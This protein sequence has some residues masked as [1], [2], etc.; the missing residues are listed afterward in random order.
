MAKAASTSPATA[1]RLFPC[2]RK[3]SRT[4]SNTLAKGISVGSWKTK[5]I[6]PS[7]S[8]CGHSIRPRLALVR[9]AISRRGGALAATRR[10]QEAH[11]L[12]P[13]DGEVEV[14]QRLRP[15]GEQLGDPAQGD[16]RRSHRGRPFGAHPPVSFF[17]RSRPCPWLT[18]FRV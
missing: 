11:E 5:P 8:P 1:A 6:S 10:A 4:L 2:R 14:R 15:V 18:N 13:A 12:V 7:P 17:R 16:Q 9:P 3:G